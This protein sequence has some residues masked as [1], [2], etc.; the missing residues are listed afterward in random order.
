MDDVLTPASSP[1]GTYIRKFS[2]MLLR[3]SED[4]PSDFPMMLACLEFLKCL[5]LVATDVSSQQLSERK[6]SG[7]KYEE[8]N[9]ALQAGV[10]ITKQVHIR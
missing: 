5:R 10:G 2:T 1:P 7:D 9:E 4:N 8:Y 6:S 3:S